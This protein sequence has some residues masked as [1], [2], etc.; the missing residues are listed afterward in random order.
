MVL[1]LPLAVPLDFLADLAA[2]GTFVAFAG[3]AL[4]LIR[5]KIPPRPRFAKRVSLSFLGSLRGAH[6]SHSAASGQLGLIQSN[7]CQALTPRFSEC[8]SRSPARRLP[9]RTVAVLDIE[10]SALGPRSYPLE[11]GL[12]PLCGP[13]KIIEVRAFSDPPGGGMDSKWS[14]VG[15]GRSGSRHPPRACS[16]R[17]LR[18]GAGFRPTQCSVR[19]ESGRHQ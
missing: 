16:E 19:V 13:N 7:R 6:Y 1:I 18:R 10:T 4:A 5:M 3:V 11:V 12:A 15:R 9:D 14:M 2:Q 8:D 17:W